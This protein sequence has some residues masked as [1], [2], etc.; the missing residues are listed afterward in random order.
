MDGCPW[1][2]PGKYSRNLSARMCGYQRLQMW[3]SSEA[4]S[5][6]GV[7]HQPKVSLTI[8]FSALPAIL[9]AGPACFYCLSALS[10]YSV[11]SSNSYCTTHPTRV[12]WRVRRYEQHA[13]PATTT[14]NAACQGHQASGS[15]A[16]AANCYHSAVVSA[17]TTR[18]D[19]DMTPKVDGLLLYGTVPVSAWRIG[20]LNHHFL[21]SQW[22]NYQ[23][24]TRRLC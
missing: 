23:C 5:E 6:S 9:F 20:A 21:R 3:L 15:Q 14:G 12:L 4:R 2:L 1:L 22:F 11:S 16:P 10:G 24:H 19:R 18:R 8:L 7:L 17:A 13:A